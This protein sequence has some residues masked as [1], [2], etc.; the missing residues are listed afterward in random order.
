[1]SKTLLSCALALPGNQKQLLS[2]EFIYFLPHSKH[3]KAVRPK[4]K[5]ELISNSVDSTEAGYFFCLIA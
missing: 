1:M 2:V 3:Q 5:W 4:K